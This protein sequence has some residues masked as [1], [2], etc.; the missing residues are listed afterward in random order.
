MVKY[1]RTLIRTFE[2][3][4]AEKIRTSSLGEKLGVLIKKKGVLYAEGEVVE[5][6]LNRFRAKG[7]TS[8]QIETSLHSF[9]TL[10]LKPYLR[11]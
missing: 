3:E 9:K 5:T 7:T 2:A 8:L 1:L 6:G 11:C 4:I 10:D